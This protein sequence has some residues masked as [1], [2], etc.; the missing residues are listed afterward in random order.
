MFPCGLDVLPLRFFFL[1]LFSRRISFR[2]PML[3]NRI[4]KSSF[5]FIRVVIF[6][7]EFE[8]FVM[9]DARVTRM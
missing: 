4:Q 6:D 7:A 2:S 8:N 3:L 5:W 1:S 9:F